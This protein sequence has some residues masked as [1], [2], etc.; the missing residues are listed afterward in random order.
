MSEKRYLILSTEDCLYSFEIEKIKKIILAKVIY[1]GEIEKL[2]IVYNI[3]IETFDNALL[4][5]F[6]V[7]N[8]E[9]I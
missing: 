7:S 4:T 1:T 3:D 8:Q 5:I 9:I 6:N 2:K